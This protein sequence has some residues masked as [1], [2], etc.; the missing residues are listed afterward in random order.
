MEIKMATGLKFCLEELARIGTRLFA[1][2]VVDGHW[3]EREESYD[4][5]IDRAAGSAAC[6]DASFN[7]IC[8]HAGQTYTE[9]VWVED[10]E[11]D[12]DIRQATQNQLQHIMN[13][14][15]WYAVR[16]E[17][18]RLLE[19]NTD[20]RTDFW[21][22]ELEKEL[23][24][25]PEK[26]KADLEGLYKLLEG[27]QKI[28]AGKLLGYTEAEVEA[29]TLIAKHKLEGSYGY[30][31]EL[32][33]RELRILYE[34]ARERKNME[35]AGRRIIDDLKKRKESSGLRELYNESEFCIVRRA[36][37]I[38]LVPLIEDTAELRKMYFASKFPEVERDAGV[39]LAE[40]TQNKTE[41]QMLYNELKVP[42]VVE[43]AGK[44]LGYSG[45]RILYH[46]SDKIERRILIGC[47][48]AA[49]GITGGIGYAMYKY[50]F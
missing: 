44:A 36:A 25:M 1:K 45:L 22:S 20:E 21:I 17:A 23:Q 5:L 8:S 40:L 18:G 19:Q 49:G 39:R 47:L 27:E 48:A 34:S 42:E 14:A 29:D 2:R 38:A 3:E 4:D 31:G 37:G 11:P 28:R 7:R 13:H 43:A 9:R 24:A 32:N 33:S 26:A 50:L 12:E 35:N 15:E 46:T 30:W 41:L 6:S 16:Y 10:S